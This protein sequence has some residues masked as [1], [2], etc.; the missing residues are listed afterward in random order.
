MGKDTIPC[1]DLKPRDEVINHALRAEF[2]KTISSKD[3]IWFAI[4]RCQRLSISKIILS[5]EKWE[6]GLPTPY[7]EWGM[8]VRYTARANRDLDDVLSYI[9]TDNPAAAEAVGIAI[10]ATA[11]RL[12]SFPLI[13]TETD[14]RGI[15]MA[16]ARPY[17]YLIFYRIDGERV[18]V[19]TIRHPAR[20][21]PFFGGGSQRRGPESRR[22]TCSATGRA[23]MTATSAR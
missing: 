18:I 6:Y 5:L 20:N 1:R 14:A 10:N 4:T 19:R 7:F 12:Q 11:A 21:W 23:S 15:Y 2:V 17:R 16:I 9:A 22:T 13:G 3:C 8:R